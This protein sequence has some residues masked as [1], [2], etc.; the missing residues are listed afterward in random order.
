MAG[1]RE[2]QRQRQT[3]ITATDDGNFELCPFEKFW[4][5]IRSHEMEKNS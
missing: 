4:S 3:D 5:S 1:F 2:A